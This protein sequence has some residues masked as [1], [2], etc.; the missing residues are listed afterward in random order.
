MLQPRGQATHFHSVGGLRDRWR[1]LVVRSDPRGRIAGEGAIGIGEGRTA[2]VGR[3]RLRGRDV[4][5]TSSRIVA[6]SVSHRAACTHPSALAALPP[7]RGRGFVAQL[8]CLELGK[9]SR[10]HA[11]LP[12]FL[13]DTNAHLEQRTQPSPCRVT[14]CKRWRVPPPTIFP[15]RVQEQAIVQSQVGAP[16]SLLHL[17]SYEI[18]GLSQLAFRDVAPQFVRLQKFFGR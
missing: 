3:G 18:V 16:W 2:I 14:Q 5:G 13:A 7:V 11:T 8:P 15:S 17:Q 1:R 6:I 4:H 12:A 10:R 9:P